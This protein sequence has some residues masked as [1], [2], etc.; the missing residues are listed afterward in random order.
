MGAK[1]L[2]VVAGATGNQGGAVA[3]ALP[4]AR[5]WR[6][7][8]LTRDPAK[9]ESKELA[10]LG[11]E[12]VKADLYDRASLDSA[13]KGAHG[14]FSVQNFWTE[15]YEGEVRQGRNLA[16]AAK[17]AGAEHF[18]YS[19]VGGADRNSGLPHFESKWEIEGHLRSLGLPTTVVRPV[20]FMD[21]FNG[22]NFQPGL[23]EG[24]LPVA[25]DPETKLQMIAV[26]D[27]GAFVAMA[28]GK[29][30][31]FMGK[32]ME[33]A[34]DELTMPE[35]AA[36]YTKVTGRKVEFVQQDI[37]EVRRANA[38]WAKMLEWFDA[39]GY[40]ADIPALRKT[41]PGLLTFA[42]WLAKSEGARAGKQA[43]TAR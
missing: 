23:L 43:A 10:R 1:R 26:E 39:A 38:E 22:P 20:F 15:G 29:P 11:V 5:G 42:Q 19:S 30:E 28:F 17:A 31:Q 25:L 2:I 27:I 40:E 32:A 14:V 41:H 24:K 35:T 4:A 6:V 37:G 34:G 12:M 7:R 9:P 21:N 8:G 13:L 3:R 33:I 36:A 18:V 16:A